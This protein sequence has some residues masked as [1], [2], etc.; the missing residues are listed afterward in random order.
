MNNVKFTKTCF[1]IFDI[2]MLSSWL[3][4][5]SIICSCAWH[6][7]MIEQDMLRKKPSAALQGVQ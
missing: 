5:P 7:L 1:K 2:Q 3:N 6:G 4:G